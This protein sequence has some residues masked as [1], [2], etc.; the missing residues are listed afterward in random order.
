ML[1]AAPNSVEH[2]QNILDSVLSCACTSSPIT[3][4]YF[5]LSPEIQIALYYGKYCVVICQSKRAE[6]II[7]KKASR[8]RSE[9]IFRFQNL[10][11]RRVLI[12][13]QYLNFRF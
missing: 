3:V 10:L 8:K 7:D 5:I 4:L 1:A 13:Y 6:L 9:M 2:E 11:I 12:Q